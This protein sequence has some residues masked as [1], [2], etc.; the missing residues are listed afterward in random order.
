MKKYLFA[1]GLILSTLLASCGGGGGG[2]T[3]VGE[4]PSDGGMTP[5]QP[6]NQFVSVSGTLS[7]EISAQTINPLATN[8]PTINGRTPSYVVAIS[9][10]NGKVLAVGS[11]LDASCSFDLKL[12]KSLSYALAIFDQDGI[13]ITALVPSNSQG[14][15]FRFL[16]DVYV[17]AVAKDTNG[18]GSPDTVEVS[19]DNPQNIQL[20]SEPALS[21]P[22]TNYRSYDRD[23][24]GKPDFMED[25]NRD[26]HLDF[27]EDKN[28]NGYPDAIEDLDGN[29]IPEGLEDE[30]KDGIPDHVE[31]MDG[32]G[33]PEYHDCDENYEFDEDYEY[34]ETYECPQPPVGGGTT[35]GNQ[36]TPNQGGNQGIPSGDQGGS[37]SGNQ[38]GGNNNQGGG[39]VSAVSF[40]NDVYPIL[41]NKCQI[42]HG[43]NSPIDAP[44]FIYSD[45]QTTYSA[46]INLVNLADPQNSRLLL[47]A[48]NQTPHEGGQ[49]IQPNSPEY[50]TILN[51]ISQG[52]QNN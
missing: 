40:S 42:C 19:V 2:D 46:V 9:V 31:D 35:G 3:E 49:V 12:D 21:E 16:G 27:M 50:Q 45:A 48:T 39:Q 33:H 25:K 23:S 6:T 28:G 17:T 22:I 37:Q 30:N 4:Y 15:G 38:Q 8:C 20:V 1:S 47:K 10:N 34:D 29:G 7:S 43:A 26:G 5:S 32:N 13:P 36:G 41:Q 11:Q 51:W 14:N 18:D 44:V 52:A 24:N